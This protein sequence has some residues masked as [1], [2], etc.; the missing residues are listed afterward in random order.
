MDS[1][2]LAESPSSLSC[3][4][5]FHL[6][7]FSSE[8]LYWS[9]IFKTSGSKGKCEFVNHSVPDY[10]VGGYSVLFYGSQC[11]INAI[12]SLFFFFSVFA[13]GVNEKA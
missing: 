12:A 11:S 3:R 10:P 2:M 4:H 7:T 8:V 5:F 13:N 6:S 1:L 9:F